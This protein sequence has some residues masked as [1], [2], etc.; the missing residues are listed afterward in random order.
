MP[1][2]GND[3]TDILKVYEGSVKF[4]MVFRNGANKKVE[5]KGAEIKKLFDDYQG[6]NLSVEEYTKRVQELQQG[7]VEALPKDAIS[8]GA[9]YQSKITNSG[10]PT[11]AEPFNTNEN[12]WWEDSNFQ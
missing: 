10:N 1:Q 9:G 12:R 7:M 3:T 5:N 6:G 4:Q 2:S 11:D 8:V